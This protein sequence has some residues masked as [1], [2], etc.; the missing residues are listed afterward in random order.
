MKRKEVMV[1]DI[2]KH[3]TRE[4]MNNILKVDDIAESIDPF[5]INVN[6]TDYE[7][8]YSLTLWLNIFLKISS[9]KIYIILYRNVPV[10][11]KQSFD[12]EIVIWVDSI[13]KSKEA[14]IDF[15]GT[16]S[17]QDRVIIV[18]GERLVPYTNCQS[19]VRQNVG[20]KELNIHLQE[21]QDWIGFS[22]IIDE[23]FFR[24]QSSISGMILICNANEKILKLITQ[25]LESSNNMSIISLGNTAVD[26]NNQ[27]ELASILNTFNSLS[28]NEAEKLIEEKKDIIGKENIAIYKGLA[29]FCNG[30]LCNTKKIL[31]DNYDALTDEIRCFLANLYNVTQEKE[32]AKKIINEIYSRDKMHR[33]IYELALRTYD[34]ADY[35]YQ[36]FLC[37]GIKYDPTNPAIIE[38]Y[39]NWLSNEGDYLGAALFFRRIPGDYFELVARINELLADNISHFSIAEKRFTPIIEENPSLFNEVVLR[40]GNYFFK[41]GSM[42]SAYHFFM[43]ANMDVKGSNIEAILL[44]KVEIFKDI[45]LASLALG[46][47]K[48]YKKEKDAQLITKE[49]GKI[50]IQLVQIFAY[51]RMG[52]VYWRELIRC[53]SEQTWIEYLLPYAIS[54]IDKLCNIDLNAYLKKSYIQNL[55]I[56]ENK[57]GADV[58]ISILRKSNAGEIL[59]ENV[60]L[61]RAEM[62][63]G[64]LVWCELNGTII[65]KAW[66]RYYLS[67]GASILGENPQEAN[68]HS[69]TICEYISLLNGSERD[70]CTLLY[71][72][73]WGNAQ[74]RIGNRIEGIICVCAAIEM[75]I[76]C[77]EIT[78]ILEEG[79]NI[80]TIFC[81]MN[82]DKI[83][84][85][86]KRE[87]ITM[88]DKLKEY[89]DT[90]RTNLPVIVGDKKEIIAELTSRIK[91][92]NKDVNWMISLAQ[93]IQYKVMYNEIPKAIDLI[94]SNIKFVK[95]LLLL[96]KDI[97]SNI[98]Y[99]WADIIYKG[100]PNI[101]NLLL[102]ID[103]LNHCEEI[104]TLRREVSHQE[105][106]SGL[107]SSIDNILRKRLEIAG[108]LWG[109]KD[110]PE[111]ITD[112]LY[113]QILN[114]SK[115]CVPLSI[116]EQKKY[117]ASKQLTEDQIK[118]SHR[119]Q[120]LNDEY[121]RIVQRNKVDS[122]YVQKIA[123]EIQ[124]LTMELKKM[125]PYYRPLSHFDGTDWKKLQNAINHDD[126]VFQFVITELCLITMLITK[127][128][129]DIKNI[130]LDPEVDNAISVMNKYRVIMEVHSGEEEKVDEASER[131]TNLIAEHLCKYIWSNKCSRVFIIPDVKYS[132]FP[133]AASIYNGELL[134]NKVDELVNFI[135][136]EAVIS[137]LKRGPIKYKYYNKLLGNHSD[138]SIGYIKLWLDQHKSDNFY[139]D[140]DSTKDINDISRYCCENN[141]N[142]FIVYGHG[143]SDV[144]SKVIDGAQDIEDASSMISIA[145]I[146]KNLSIENT[147]VISCM[148]GV[149][150][151]ENPDKSNGTWTQM[152]EKQVGVI[153]MCKWSVATEETIQLLDLVLQI[154]DQ[155]SETIGKALIRAQRELSKTKN[156][157]YWAGIE[158]WV[159]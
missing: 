13:P 149:P 89:N 57:L 74:Y 59:P 142:T 68:D 108:L 5:T 151:G 104:F 107:A 100:D 7:P 21:D 16:L 17:K 29:Y 32:E 126:V 120:L 28:V 112:I 26:P 86:N 73:S 84:T 66:I 152:F 85:S 30:D 27:V 38:T 105:E 115:K 41:K 11:M 154:L 87:F 56:D 119:L 54:Q 125:H 91:I 60:E 65:E 46:K 50:L 25:V 88:L 109:I 67:I 124:E 141:Y 129:I 78:P 144:T 14:I 90:V 15:I 93:L 130:I 31:Y 138:S 37:E 95:P 72:L 81:L 117:N 62:E 127:N 131:I 137:Y 4:K 61:S 143:V 103:L 22:K 24:I 139:V 79:L 153:I 71:L 20:K 70:I 36:K 114:T 146:I 159:N 34:P 40:L 8:Y 155:G 2:Y 157:F 3:H 97:A 12:G 101:N 75:A 96:R 48:P 55:H 76:T 150:N 49:R 147:F 133:L 98:L 10:K 33:G 58:C 148:A 77:N 1:F 94:K 44:K 80:I 47:R 19:V 43:K 110:A 39:A 6:T 83:T 106:R 42:Y 118:K 64:A 102:A 116:I 35:E 156:L 18:G 134:I 52:Y 92:S 9:D 23:V 69:L 145:E 63:R 135:D 113:P 82:K 136:Y 111:Y 122:P 99:S 45:K 158:M 51:K 140:T 53:Q 128:N 121:L 123:Q 132:S